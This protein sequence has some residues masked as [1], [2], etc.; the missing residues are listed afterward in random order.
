MFKMSFLGLIPEALVLFVMAIWE[1]S[2]L[3]ATYQY[4]IPEAK[5]RKY[6]DA[7]AEFI[8]FAM[9]PAIAE[10]KKVSQIKIWRFRKVEFISSVSGLDIF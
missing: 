6:K 7:G 10:G 5:W 2:H 9:R 3:A 4:L 8:E 1:N